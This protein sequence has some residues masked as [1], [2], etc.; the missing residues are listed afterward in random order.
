MSVSATSGS[1]VAASHA[2]ALQTRPESREVKKTGRD[3]SN[4]GDGDDGASKAAATKPTVN[5][6]GPA[7][8]S[9]V[10]TKA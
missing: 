8:G 3:A 4:D 5:L 6:T 9:V 10:N 2:Q 1:N 7:L